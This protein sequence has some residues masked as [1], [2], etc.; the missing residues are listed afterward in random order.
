MAQGEFYV[1]RQ[2]WARWPKALIMCRKRGSMEDGS[3]S[4]ERRRYVPEGGAGAAEPVGDALDAM[5]RRVRELEAENERLRGRCDMLESHIEG[6][7]GWRTSCAALESLVADMYED[8]RNVSE[9][10]AYDGYR[11]RM[12][13][14]GIDV[15]EG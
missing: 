11:E 2:Y 4:V 14:L 5:Q 6:P 15:E 10:W 7:L 3:V 13:E 9:A 12:A 1:E 8:M